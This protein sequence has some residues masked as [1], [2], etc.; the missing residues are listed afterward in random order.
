MD[1]EEEEEEEEVSCNFSAFVMT[2]GGRSFGVISPGD[3]RVPPD[4]KE[5]AASAGTTAAAATP[6]L[7]ST[8]RRGI[9]ANRFPR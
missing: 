1:E 7:G 4:R 9:S 8:W 5:S 3:P 6:L 2:G